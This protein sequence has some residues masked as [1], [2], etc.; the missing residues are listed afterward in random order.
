MTNEELEAR[1]RKT[2]DFQEILNL[3]AEYGYHLQMEGP[4][5]DWFEKMANFF[6][7]DSEIELSDSGKFYGK[8][9]LTKLFKSRKV[10]PAQLSI[11]MMIQPYIKIY[12]NNAEAIWR[13]FGTSAHFIEMEGNGASKKLTAF[14]QQGIYQMAYRKENGAW[15]I[16]KL[17]FRAIF[18]SPYEDGWVK[19]PMAGTMKKK[20]LQSDAP[21]SEKRGYNPD[22]KSFEE[23]LVL[24]ILPPD[25]E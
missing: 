17:A 14:W 21:T 19:T 3:Q 18:R 11:V 25:R 4:E 13:G 2:E 6:T 23:R 20:G 10:D 12:G 22:A 8:E 15:K 5:S 24:P 16:R 7:D 9:G 1:V